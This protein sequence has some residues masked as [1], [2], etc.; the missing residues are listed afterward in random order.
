MLKGRFP[1][2]RQIRLLI[3]EDVRYLRKIL[4][5]IDATVVL[6][7]M[8]VEFGEE[9]QEDWIDF[10]NFSDMD[11]WARAP[12]EEDNELNLPIP[13]NAPKHKIGLAQ[14]SADGTNPNP[15]ILGG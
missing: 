2:L 7:N 3:K 15:N 6:H 11:D 8:L 4:F 10:D 1:W 5:L 14:A 12:Y 9:E 13:E